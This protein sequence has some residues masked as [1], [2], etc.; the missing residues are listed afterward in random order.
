MV[1][2][3]LLDRV[4]EDLAVELKF[5]TYS[6]PV[7]L[8][9][10]ARLEKKLTNTSYMSGQDAWSL[11]RRLGSQVP[12]PPPLSWTGSTTGRWTGGK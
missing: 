5:K 4:Q 10:L 2:A 12:H 3:W 7:F 8:Y 11:E 6:L 1:L 9:E